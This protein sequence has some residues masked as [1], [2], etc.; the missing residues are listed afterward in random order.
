MINYEFHKS[1]ISILLRKQEVLFITISKCA[2]VNANAK[3]LM[4]NA[5]FMTITSRLFIIRNHKISRRMH[6]FE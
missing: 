1:Y 5:I 4:M 2:N 6:L 3:T